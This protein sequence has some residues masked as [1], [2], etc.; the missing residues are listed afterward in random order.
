[1]PLA[2]CP[3]SWGQVASEWAVITLGRLEL[4][5]APDEFTALVEPPLECGTIISLEPEANG[6]SIP[7]T[8]IVLVDVLP[9]RVYILRIQEYRSHV[10]QAFLKSEKQERKAFDRKQVGMLR[11]TNLNVT[12][13]FYKSRRPPFSSLPRLYHHHSRAGGNPEIGCV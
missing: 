3:L 5:C 12:R 6:P 1:M 2:G 8:P 7:E 4:T 10:G 11:T 9:G 13:R